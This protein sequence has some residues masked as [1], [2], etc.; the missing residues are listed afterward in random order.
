MSASC[1][2]LAGANCSRPFILNSVSYS[3]PSA[4]LSDSPRGPLP[5]TGYLLL[6]AAVAACHCSICKPLGQ[7]T[8]ITLC[9]LVIQDSA[10][11]HSS[12]SGVCCSTAPL[13]A[14][15]LESN[16]EFEGLFVTTLPLPC[17]CHPPHHCCMQWSGWSRVPA[18]GCWC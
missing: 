16:Y 7:C 9:A 6:M 5:V 8:Y 3:S 15:Y 2:P 14:S 1:I 12:Y 4:A 18:A 10:V 17:R 13:L 11:Q